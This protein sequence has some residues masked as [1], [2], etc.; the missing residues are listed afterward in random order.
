MMQNEPLLD[1]P[2]PGQSLTAGLGDRPWQQVSQ[3]QTVEDAVE[4]YIPRLGDPSLINTTLRIIDSG[5]SLTTI[6]E[7]LTLN[8]IMEGRHTV[9]VAILVNP[10]IVEFLKGLGDL[11]GIDY[12]IDVDE[13]NKT[14][15]T[16]LDAAEAEQELIKDEDVQDLM[17][18]V[19]EET[20]DTKDV[21]EETETEPKGL[22][23]RRSS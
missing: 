8:G 6:A 13:N 10:V 7:V 22:M 11:A 2:I 3:L 15:I 14:D 12:T 1:A 18:D 21:T 20:S 16:P 9:D 23:A 4:Y 19:I 5:A 17:E